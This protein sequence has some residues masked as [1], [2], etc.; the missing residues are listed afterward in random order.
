MFHRFQFFDKEQLIESEHDAISVCKISFPFLFFI[1]LILYFFIALFTFFFFRKL[2]L[3]V[4][5]VAEGLLFWVVCDAYYNSF[6]DSYG[7]IHMIDRE[8]K[9]TTFSAFSQALSHI[10]LVKDKNILVAVGNEDATMA[11]TVKLFN[12]DKLDQ[13]GIPLQLKDFKLGDSRL[14]INVPVTCIDATDDLSKIAIG[15]CNGVSMFYVK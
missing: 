10:K 5:Q 11:P 4:L 8:Y 14:P 9:V 2:H 1:S 15:F 3:L 13:N 6:L 12:M 7:L